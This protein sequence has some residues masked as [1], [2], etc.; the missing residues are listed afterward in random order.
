M[1]EYL[2][3]RIFLA[4][5]TMLV[6]IIVSYVLLRMAPGDPTK[7]ASV[8]S[9]TSGRNEGMSS[10]KGAFAQNRSMREQLY[11]DKPVYVGLYFWL[12]NILLHWDFGVSASVDAGRP[13][14][15]LIADRLQVTV[16]L[17]FWAVVVVYLL[18]IPLGI[19]SALHPDSIS[20]RFITFMLFFLYSLPGLWVALVLQAGLC[21]GGWLPVFP[22]KG[23]QS[24]STAGLSSWRV[25][26]S[27]IM[28]YILPVT[29]L[30]YA[31]L[32][33][34]SRYTRSGMIEVLHQDYI[35]SARAKGLSEFTVVFKHAFRNTLIIMITLF[36]GL[37]PGLISGSV[38][39]ENVFSIPGMGTLALLA[40]NSRDYPLQMAILCFGSLLT[41]G[42]I[43]I[44]DLLYVAADPRITF[45]ARNT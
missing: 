16:N 40:L 22:L 35:R 32:A 12:K 4:I 7:S 41:L 39:I 44:A 34:L 14:T 23:L 11:L 33:A 27:S 38:I 6:I 13:V 29:C 19:C 1:F 3:K 36:A 24:G 21:E 20:D 28:H 42:G 8:L 18:A 43:L 17:N 10:E 30:A 15:E 45:N 2:L 5:M 9:E 37:L 31:G 25:L 26:G